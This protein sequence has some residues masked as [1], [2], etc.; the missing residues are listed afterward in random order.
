MKIDP[1]KKYKTRSGRPVEFLHRAPEGW[2]GERPWRGIVA[3]EPI[4]WRDN[5]S[6]FN[7]AIESADD[8]VEVREPMMIKMWIKDGHGPIFCVAD[9]ELNILKMNVLG[10]TLKEFVEVMP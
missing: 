5:G 3:G 4:T 7:E 6:E 1:S 2:P 9:A 8:L 10:Y